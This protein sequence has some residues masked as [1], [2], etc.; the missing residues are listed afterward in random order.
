MMILQSI[1]FYISI[2]CSKTICKRFLKIKTKENR[3]R[4]CYDLASVSYRKRF[5]QKIV[6]PLEKSS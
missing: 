2:A 3:N 5:C 6:N 4:F 1:N